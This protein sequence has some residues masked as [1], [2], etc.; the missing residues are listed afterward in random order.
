MRSFTEAIFKA[1]LAA[2]LVASAT[3]CDDDEEIAV[4]PPMNVDSGTLLRDASESIAPVDARV[5][6]SSALQDAGSPDATAD[7][8]VSFVAENDRATTGRGVTVVLKV[9]QNDT[10][11]DRAAVSVWSFTNGSHGRVLARADGALSYQPDE[12]FDGNDSFTY[13][14]RTV[15]G[16]SATATVNIKVLPRRG[17][18]SAGVLFIGTE[19]VP[20]DSPVGLRWEDINASGTRVGRLLPDDVPVLGKATGAI[21]KIVLPG[22]VTEVYLR[23]INEAGLIT[24]FATANNEQK[25]FVFSGTDVAFWPGDSSEY[26]PEGIGSDGSVVGFVYL[27]DPP[28]GYRGFIRPAAGPIAHLQRTAGTD[29]VFGGISSSGAIVGYTGFGEGARCFRRDSAGFSDLP[30]P[31]GYA[32]YAFRCQ[33]INKNGEVV[34]SVQ[35]R[36]DSRRS[37]ALWTSA[38]FQKIHFPFPLVAG[39]TGRSEVLTGINDSGTMVGLY[40]ETTPYVDAGEKKTRVVTHAVELTPVPAQTDVFF[41]D[42]KYGLVDAS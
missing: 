12:G 29:T 25:V 37:A 20:G 1:V 39:A 15:S 22:T 17:T 11:A 31:T 41:E 2:S 23:A 6:D 14:A 8:F 13:V 16:Q 30:L 28:A 35:E 10:G 4:I 9:L 33:A 26:T 19:T 5:P 27:S 36:S 21:E 34:G 40:S 7:T 3:S 18:V 24:G 38:G 42:T 32:P